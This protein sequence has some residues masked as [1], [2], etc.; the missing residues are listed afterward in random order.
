MY[1]KFVVSL[2]GYR[3]VVTARIDDLIPKRHFLLEERQFV[4]FAVSL[5]LNPIG[6]NWILPVDNL[7]GGIYIIADVIP[8]L[9]S[10]K[11]KEPVSCRICIT[12]AG[13]EKCHA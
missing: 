4:G 3:Y 10:L 7:I 6:M 13:N 1:Q 2:K 9:A 12:D 11:L 8:V 5:G